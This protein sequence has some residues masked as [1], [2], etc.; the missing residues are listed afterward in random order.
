MSETEGYILNTVQTPQPLETVYRSIQR[1]QTTKEKIQDDT[2]LPESLLKQGL[3]GLQEIGLIGRQEPDYYT[4]EPPWQTGD[5]RLDFRMAVLHELATDA[6]RDDWGKQSVVLL[7]Y[8]YL[9]QENV[10]TFESNAEGVYSSMNR[11]G[12][13]RGYEP[14]S[15]Q[16]AIDMNE[17]KMVNWTR[18]VE[19]LGLVY[20]A[21]GRT[22]VTRPDE[23]LVYYSVVKATDDAEEDR[24]TIQSYIDWLNENLLLVD[25]TSGGE[26]PG[27]LARVLFDLVRDNRIRI[28]EAGDAGSV[29]L[30]GVPTIP[31]IDKEANSIE[32]VA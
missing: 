5:D 15:Q 12:R 23:E 21:N 2:G 20:K 14:L 31:G 24:I 9:L 29:G 10:Q 28:V 25:L 1:G 7:N 17:P 30:Q 3:S 16:G 8:Q 13:N 27:P 4:V 32:V 11:F 6:D 18:L 22:H 26:L 19:F